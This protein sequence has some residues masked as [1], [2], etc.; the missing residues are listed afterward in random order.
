MAEVAD[1]LTK[2]LSAEVIA[3]HK[4]SLGVG[5]AGSLSAVMPLSSVRSASTLPL[6]KKSWTQ[7]QAFFRSQLRTT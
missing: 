5:T 4:Q 3:R 6:A 1:I 7:F 2:P